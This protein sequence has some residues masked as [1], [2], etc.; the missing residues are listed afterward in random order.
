[1]SVGSAGREAVE[2][3]EGGGE[4]EVLGRRGGV[5]VV[6]EEREEIGDEVTGGGAGE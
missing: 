1:M 6:E 3:R 2:E 4:M 5:R